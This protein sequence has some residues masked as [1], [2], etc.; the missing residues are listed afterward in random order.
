MTDQP[1]GPPVSSIQT[2]TDDPSKL[3]HVLYGLYALGFVTGGLTSIAGFILALLMRDKHKTTWLDSHLTWLIRTA[4]VGF[5]AGAI[6][7]M[8]IIVLIGFPILF[9]VAIWLIYRIVKGWLAVSEG[10]PLATP[11]AWI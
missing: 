1:A 6:G 2:L 8:L 10:K 3:G 5:V 11:E 4:I 9:A 7:T